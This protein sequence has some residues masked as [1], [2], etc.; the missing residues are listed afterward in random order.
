MSKKTHL[1]YNKEKIMNPFEKMI[2]ASMKHMEKIPC[3]FCGK[4]LHSLRTSSNHPGKG[5]CE[6]CWENSKRLP[7]Y[8]EKF[9][10]LSEQEKA[11][12]IKQILKNE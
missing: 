9:S 10:N 12:E 2:K 8:L 1:F 5:V 3:K 4:E 6:K 11:E 7:E